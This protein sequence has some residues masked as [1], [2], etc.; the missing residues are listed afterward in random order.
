MSTCGTAGPGD[1]L[2]IDAEFTG[3]GSDVAHG[4]F[5]IGTADGWWAVIAWGNCP[6]LHADAD[7]TTFCETLTLGNELV[8]GSSDPATAEKVDDCGSVIGGF[9][10]C[11]FVEKDAQWAS[12][13]LFIS[14]GK[15]FDCWGIGGPNKEEQE[16]KERCVETFG[17]HGI[18]EKGNE[19]GKFSQG[20]F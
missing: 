5:G 9:P 7:G 6:I 3:V 12:R 15:S 4:R 14:D 18:C 8:G 17:C 11:G 1:A 20:V 19:L 10:A 13:N 16:M 2:G